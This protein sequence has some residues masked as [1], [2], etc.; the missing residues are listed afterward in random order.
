MMEF[1]ALTSV[2]VMMSMV[3]LIIDLSMLWVYD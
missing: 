1:N 2:I 3:L